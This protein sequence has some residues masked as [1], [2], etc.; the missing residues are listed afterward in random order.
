MTVKIDDAKCNGFDA[1]PDNGACLSAC[2]LKMIDDN[3]GRPKPKILG[4]VDC[5]LCIKACPN[6]AISK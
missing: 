6:E 1:C 5:G 3:N 2:V 4:C